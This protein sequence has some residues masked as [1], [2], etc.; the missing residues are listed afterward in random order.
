MI[1]LSLNTGEYQPGGYI[2]VSRAREFY[3]NFTSKYLS[4]TSKLE[5]VVLADALNFL[6]IDNGTAT[7]RYST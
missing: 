7:L 1:P 5:I 2:N 6:L 4:P 3:L